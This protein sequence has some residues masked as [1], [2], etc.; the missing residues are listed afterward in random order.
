[1]RIFSKKRF[2]FDHPGGIGA[3]GPV[4]TQALSFHDV[5]DW[6][7][8]SS[9]FKLAYS[10]GDVAITNGKADETAVE[11]A[12]HAEKQRRRKPKTE[13]PGE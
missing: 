13:E 8:E 9:M 3:G 2:R 11:E 6:V 1:M 7:K 5:P 4:Y 10:A 12:A